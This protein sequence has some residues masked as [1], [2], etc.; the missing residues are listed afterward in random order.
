MAS[1]SANYQLIPDGGNGH[2]L[3]SCKVYS[4]TAGTGDE[5]RRER[6]K[7]KQGLAPPERSRARPTLFTERR[8]TAGGGASPRML[9]NARDVPLRR[10]ARKEDGGRRGIGRSHFLN[11][12]AS[13]RPRT[14]FRIPLQERQ[15]P[16][17]RNASGQPRALST[18]FE[19]TP[20]GAMDKAT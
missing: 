1:V 13:W 18:D 15:G 11:G 14:G 5:G 9:D 4:E 12:S 10:S 16:R 8:W 2:G 20:K 19:S 7:K 6:E 17:G 3:T